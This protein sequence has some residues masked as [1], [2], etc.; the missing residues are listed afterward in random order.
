MGIIIASY[1]PPLSSPPPPPTALEPHY[2]PWPHAVWSPNNSVSTS[3]VF[4][5]TAN[6]LLAGPVFYIGVYSPRDT[7]FLSPSLMSVR[8]G[9]LCRYL[10]YTWHRPR[11]PRSQNI[12]VC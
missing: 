1:P 6:S 2:W 3:R 10:H 7:L 4:K 9:W 11:L 5:S 8:L 12:M